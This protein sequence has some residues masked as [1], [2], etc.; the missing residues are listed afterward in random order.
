MHH[1]MID[2]PDKYS[3]VRSHITGSSSKFSLQKNG[4]LTN[5]STMKLNKPRISTASE[6]ITSTVSHENCHKI[7]FQNSNVSPIRKIY[8]LSSDSDN[9]LSDDE[10][11]YNKLVDA[12]RLTEKKISK[13]EQHKNLRYEKSRKDSFREDLSPKKSINLSTPAL[14]QFCED[15]FKSIKDIESGGNREEDMVF[16]SSRVADAKR[17]RNIIGN[18]EQ[19]CNLPNAEPPSFQYFY[20][21]DLR[22]QMLV[23]QRLPYFVPLGTEV[24]KQPGTR[25]IDYT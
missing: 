22:I 7:F 17:H 9:P 19:N 6:D 24:Q 25:N 14:D 1:L 12:N 3:S 16:C 4:V 2:F 8:L 5:Q 11:K 23:K 15:Y 20:H 13:N 18:A 21:N 10:C